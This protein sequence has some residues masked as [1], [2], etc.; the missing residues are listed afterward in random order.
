MRQAAARASTLHR[1][2]HIKH[3]HI[4]SLHHPI[5]LFTFRATSAIAPFD[6][7]M[8]DDHRIRSPHRGRADSRERE[9]DYQ[10]RPDGYNPSRQGKP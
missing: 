8:H 1:C 9:R 3:N 5:P 4:T 10:G 2:D 7:A 6:T